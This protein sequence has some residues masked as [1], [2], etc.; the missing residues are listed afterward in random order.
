MLKKT[1]IFAL[2]LIVVI[3]LVFTQF[4]KRGKLV[5]EGKDLSPYIEEEYSDKVALTL[6][7]AGENKGELVKFL[8]QVNPAYKKGASFLV[9]YMPYVDGVEITSEALLD[10]ID[11][12][13][14]AKEEFSW[15]KDLPEDIFLNYLLPYRNS[16]E[17]IQNWRPFFYERFYPVVKDL[18]LASEA[19]RAVNRWVVIQE[20]VV[21]VQKLTELKLGITAG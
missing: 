4:L 17:P 12:A 10:N 8:T 16:Q 6:E 5:F 13:Y 9:A 15:A 21:E 11:Y 20:A 19:G 3:I 2:L 14:K 7:N 1:L 18:S